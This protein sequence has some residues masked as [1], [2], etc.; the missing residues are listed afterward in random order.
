MKSSS[1][2]PNYGSSAHYLDEEGKKYFAGQQQ[3]GELSAIWNR[4]YFSF[5]IKPSDMILDFGCGGANLL[6]MLPG[7]GKFGVEINPAARAYAAALGLQVF[8]ALDE[9]PAGPYDVILSSHALEH[10][11]NPL[12]LLEEL[13]GMLAA[14]GVFILLLP[15]DDWRAPAHRVYKQDDIHHHLYNWTPQNLGNLLSEAGFQVGEIKIIHDAMPAR[16]W[17]TRLAMKSALLQTVTGRI[18]SLLLKRNQL[19]ALCT[20]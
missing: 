9:A 18:F 19:F 4:R 17:I 8:A 7:H 13:A 2:T 6:A 1:S 5:Y 3:I 20:K 10:V 14:D 11:P 16:P 12:T 15:L